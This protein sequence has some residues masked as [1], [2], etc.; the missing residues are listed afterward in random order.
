M[1]MAGRVEVSVVVCSQYSTMKLF[2]K[3]LESDVVK[4]ACFTS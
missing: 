3:T 2:R 1:E 4:V